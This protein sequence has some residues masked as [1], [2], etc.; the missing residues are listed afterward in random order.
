MTSELSSDVTAVITAVITDVCDVS[1]TCRND[2][3]YLVG[4]E[5]LKYFELKDLSLDAA[6]RCFLKRLTL[7][8]ETQECERILAH[9]SNHYVH[10]NTGVFNSEGKCVHG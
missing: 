5:Y 6:L 7:T 8:G 4:D 2:F 1:S 9:F 10:C 3:A